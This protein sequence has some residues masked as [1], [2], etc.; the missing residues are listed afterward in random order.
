MKLIGLPLEIIR[1]I[2]SYLYFNNLIPEREKIHQDIK[3]YNNVVYE[4]LRSTYDD[5]VIMRR[6]IRWICFELPMK[7]SKDILDDIEFQIGSDKTRQHTQLIMKRLK[8]VQLHEMYRMCQL[9]VY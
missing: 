1:K 5:D 8:M 7:E 2:A 6:M 3:H 4:S 9:Y